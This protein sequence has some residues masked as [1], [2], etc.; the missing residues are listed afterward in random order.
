M[1]TLTANIQANTSGFKSAVE[2]AKRELELFNKSNKA[3]AQTMKGCNDVTDLQIS[4]FSKSVNAL[5]KASAGTKTYKQSAALLEKE[6]QK[7]K[8]QWDNLSETAKKSEFGR[9]MSQSITQTKAKLAEL[10]EEMAKPTKSWGELAGQMNIAGVNVGDVI[11]KLK[12]LNPAVIGVAGAAKIMTD[13]FKSSETAMDDAKRTMFGLQNTYDTF[14]RQVRDGNFYISNIFES[15]RLG[16]EKYDAEDA[17]GSLMA[18]NKAVYENIKATVAE[19]QATVA[20]GGK[21]NTADIRESVTKMY[22]D[23]KK[24]TE[25]TF[26]ASIK[27]MAGGNSN[28]ESLIRRMIFSD[29]PNAELAKMQSEMNAVD[30]LMKDWAGRHSQYIQSMAPGSPGF[31]KWDSN[32]NKKTYEEME[33]RLK[34]IRSVIDDETAIQTDIIEKQSQ[35]NA[36]KRDEAAQMKIIANLDRRSLSNTNKEI[37]NQE[38]IL[39]AQQETVVE[40]SIADYQA[41]IAELKKELNNAT[42][43]S[44]YSA[45]QAKIDELNDLIRQIEGKAS[46]TF[47]FAQYQRQDTKKSESKKIGQKSDPYRNLNSAIS[48]A[49]GLNSSLTSI[50]DTMTNIRDIENPFQVFDTL[51]GTAK[52]VMGV[53]KSI[54]SLSQAMNAMSAV[55]TSTANTEVANSNAETAANTSQAVSETLAQNAKLGP[56]VGTT[57]GV[58]MA[59]TV[60]STILSA[61]KKYAGGGII[62]GSSSLGDYNIA[63]VNSGEMILNGTQQRRLFNLANGMGGGSQETMEMP[64]VEFV[65]KGQNLVGVYNNY[66]NKRN[67]V[68]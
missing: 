18:N 41:K 30:K 53:V 65:I 29:D 5:E 31:I 20:E 21:V 54:E 1:S 16:K 17:L 19:A 25:K 14:I 13:A 27:S 49:D 9:H 15:F 35:L 59:A 55:S 47:E 45:I 4:A 48:S 44:A 8:Q 63:R 62:G 12:S 64:Q 46:H 7:L 26:E 37:K 38:K 60:L 24:A 51:I 50:Y 61:K 34:A 2:G 56:I 6:L 68:R 32:A 52:N 33:Q 57:M 3:L 10:N 40:G 43:Y 28:K 11:G 36:L 66:N 67:R 42:E 23:I 39:K 22:A 58:A